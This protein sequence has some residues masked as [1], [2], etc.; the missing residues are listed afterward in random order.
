MSHIRFRSSISLSYRVTEG[1]DT[2]HKKVIDGSLYY[3]HIIED[4]DIGHIRFIVSITLPYRSV[5]IE[6]WHIRA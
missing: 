6:H 4:N 3:I 1:S 5:E 2:G